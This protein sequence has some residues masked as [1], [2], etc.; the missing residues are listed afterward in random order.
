MGYVQR[1]RGDFNQAVENL[2]KSL[3]I[4]P[5]FSLTAFN[6]GSTLAL[7]LSYKE[8]EYFYNRANVLNPEFIHPYSKKARLYLLW[9]GNTKKSRA[10]MEEASRTF[11]SLDEHLV[12]YPWIL[13]EIYDGQ[14]Q[15]A[16][17]RLSTVQAEAFQYGPLFVPKARIIAQKRKSKESVI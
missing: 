12:V 7:M 6:I 4:D 5:R 13:I 14:Y 16:L 15:E 3:E 11:V 8:A 2:K 10:V 9:E 1:R 17:N